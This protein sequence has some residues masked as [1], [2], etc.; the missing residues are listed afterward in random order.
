MAETNIEWC[1]YTFNPWEGCTKVS[2]GCDNCYAEARNA[3]FG[4]GKAPNWGVGAPRRRTGAA[5]WKMPLK[6]NRQ[7]SADGTRPRVFCASL[8]DWLD[9]EAPI[10]WLVD[11]LDLIRLTPN[12]DWLLLTKRIGT[13]SGRIERA[14]RSLERSQT[15]RF[16]LYQWLIQWRDGTAPENVWLGISVVNQAEAD[17]DVDRLLAAPAALRFLSCEPLLGYLDLET[18]HNDISLGEGQPYL[19]PLLG[20]VGDGHGDSCRV[21][22]IDWVIAGGESGPGARP[23]HLAWARQLRDQC[24]V[25]GVPFLFKQW[26]EWCP[27]GPESLGYP[28]HDTPHQIRLTDAGENGHM[29]GAGGDNHVHMQRAGKKKAGRLLDGVLHNEFPVRGQHGA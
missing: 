16:G 17:R 29:L 27:R 20:L 19:H 5:S 10:E 3:R 26:G 14:L 7:A 21:A 1:D 4:G 8:A 11:L 12:L 25:A 6:W 13:F 9:K 23:M 24:A 18:L 28:I 2:P 22:R 15:G